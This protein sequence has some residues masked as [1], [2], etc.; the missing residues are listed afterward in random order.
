MK[1]IVIGG[2][3]AGLMAAYTAAAKCE[4]LLLEK[5]EKL[6]KKIYIT[7]KGRCNLANYCDSR[8]FLKNVVSNQKF[9]Y[10]AISRFDPYSTVALFNELGLETKTERGNRVFPVSDH[11]SDVTKVL[12]KAARKAGVKIEL[13]CAVTDIKTEQGCFKAVRTADGREIYADACIIATGGLSYPSTGSTGDGYDFAVKA[14]HTVTKCVPS[15]VGL[16]TKET[17]VQEMEGLSLK[18]VRLDVYLNGKKKYSDFGEMLFTHN[19]VSGPLVLTASAMFARDLAAGADV[20]LFIDLKPA[21]EQDVLDERLVREFSETSNKELKNALK[22]LLPSSMIPVFIKLAGIS[23][24]RKVNT[25]TAPERKKIRN[26][27]K[28]FELNVSEAGGFNEAVITQGGVKVN[29][30]DPKTMGS[31]LVKNLY[32]AGE[33]IDVDAFTGGFNLQIAWSTGV[34][35]ATGIIDQLN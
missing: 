32:F 12:E 30:I 15:L 14:G 8:T 18:N 10:S 2:G 16:K 25:I 9:L 31:K 21:L 7:G 28:A 19:G 22:S 3:A 27:L 1:I 5:N 34:A 20:K 23:G 33:V 29:E 26:L 13:N 6:G 4:V 24:E 17:F 11:A 35:A